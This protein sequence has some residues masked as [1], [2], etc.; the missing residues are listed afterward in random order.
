MRVPVA[1]AALLLLVQVGP[2]AAQDS[3]PNR[4]IRII[5]PYTPGTGADILSR[6]MGPKL[7]ERWKVPVITDNKPGASSILGAELVAN[8]T[9]DGYT[10]LFTA[11]S[12]GTSPPLSQKMPY[13]PIKSFAPV[14]LLATNV[15]SFCLANNVP[16]KTLAEFIALA[17]SQPGKLNYASPGSGTPQHLAMELFKLETNLDIVHVPYRASGPA[18]ADLVGGHVQAMVIPLQTAA[19]F[20][21][22]GNVRAVAL[23]SAQR[24]PAFPDV[25]TMR[26]QG[27][28]AIEVDT[29]YGALAP[30]GTPSAI[31]AKWN[32]EL[33]SVLQLPDIRE[34]MEKQGMVPAGGPPDRMGKLLADEL[35]RWTRV[36][37][38]AGIKAD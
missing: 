11:T 17:R 9:P 16:A 34:A 37:N 5:V 12:F 33:T 18:T 19:P 21:Q 36:V 10:I 29:W 35:E 3:Y 8:A 22:N 24:S 31:I 6:L 27:L 28:P 14:S 1:L 15:V 23:M 25:P 4:P 38:A 26:E 2:V 30:A 13:D 32:A 20:I 7:A